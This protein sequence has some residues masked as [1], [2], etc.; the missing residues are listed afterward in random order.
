[1]SAEF[2]WALPV[3]IDEDLPPVNVAPPTDG[4][5]AVVAL[6]ADEGPRAEGWPAR[7]AV[8]LAREWA[9]DGLRVFLV[10]GDLERPALHGVIGQENGE[11]LAD[12]VMYGASPGRIG[13][14]V[15]D[16]GFVFASAGTVVPDPVAA[17]AHPRWDALLD[18]FRE[19]GSLLLLYL[20]AGDATGGLVDRA[21]RVLRLTSEPPGS[22]PGLGHLYVHPAAGGEAVAESPSDFV[23]SDDFATG[24][25]WAEEAPEEEDVAGGEAEEIWSGAGD[26]QITDEWAGDGPSSLTGPGDGSP[27]AEAAPG[28]PDHAPRDAAELGAPAEPADAAGDP[29][30]HGP[31]DD[32]PDLRPA[33]GSEVAA[34]GGREAEPRD[35]GPPAAT[36]EGETA[37]DAV[38]ATGRSPKP[39][40]RARPEKRSLKPWLLLLVLVLAAV[41]VADWLGYITIPGLSFAPFGGE[42]GLSGSAP[43]TSAGTG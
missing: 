23:L 42:A 18:A 1:M 29:P 31:T 16:G 12:A 24:A 10:D 32:D 15:A 14:P 7:V 27:A 26:L 40:V 5:G 8:S 17:Y 6:V 41:F 9:A 20:P 34:E 13:R 38:L 2:P 43:P 3:R 25:D 22:D 37:P 11:G 21:D 19:S 35:P 33:G 36:D 39:A 30:E 28:E 4:A